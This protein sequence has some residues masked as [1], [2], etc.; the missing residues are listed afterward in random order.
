MPNRHFQSIKKSVGW[1]KAGKFWQDT[2]QW[3]LCLLQYSAIMGALVVISWTSQNGGQSSFWRYRKHIFVFSANK[4]GTNGILWWQH[5]DETQS[6][7]AMTEDYSEVTLTGAQLLRLV[8][9]LIGCLA[10][11][12]HWYSSFSSQKSESVFNQVCLTTQYS[13]LGSIP[14]CADWCPQTRTVWNTV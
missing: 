14:K 4:C 9:S 10:R 11:N 5:E 1:E 2:G 8:R 13:V 6:K 12:F 7:L 3:N